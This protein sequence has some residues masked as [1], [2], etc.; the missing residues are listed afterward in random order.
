MGKNFAK[1]SKA[2]RYVGNS[3]DVYDVAI[4][5][6]KATDTNNYRPF[7]IKLEALAAGRVA[8]AITAFAF[9][10]IVG[11]PMGILGFALIM[12]VVGVMVDEKLMAKINKLVGI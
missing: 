4:E 12:T 1:F 6:Y 2:F 8:T 5:F 9:S 3:V 7:F 11:T 10:L